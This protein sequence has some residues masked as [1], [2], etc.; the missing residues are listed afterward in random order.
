MTARERS[1]R[2][3]TDALRAVAD[4]DAGIGAS[5]AV[6]VRLREVVRAMD[7]SHRARPPATFLALAAALV[8]VVSGAWRLVATHA[9]AAPHVVTREVATEFLPLT[10]AQWQV[11][12]AYIIRLDIPR[13]ALMAFGLGSIDLTTDQPDTVEADVL[14]GPDG[15]AR[16]V[17]FV[18]RIKGGD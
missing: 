5:P 7:A 17:R 8:V 12:D 3:L 13:S 14:V 10:Y 2:T 18:H 11:T 4:A 15:L 6:E 9:P 1:P 16:A